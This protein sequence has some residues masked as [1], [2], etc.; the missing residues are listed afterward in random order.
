MKVKFYRR[1]EYFCGDGCCLLFGDSDVAVVREVTPEQ[2]AHLEKDAD[3]ANSTYWTDDFGVEG[4][5]EKFHYF[6]V[7]SD[8]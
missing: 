1:D 7:D 6:C 2:L 3:Y 5:P 4:E 8:D